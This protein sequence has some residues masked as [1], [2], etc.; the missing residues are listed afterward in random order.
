MVLGGLALGVVFVA[1]FVMRTLY[2]ARPMYLLMVILLVAGIQM[3][4]FG[5]I[6]NQ[7]GNIKKEIY[8]LQRQRKQKNNTWNQNSSDE[9]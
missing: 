7:I 1:Q 6:S 2:P 5:F 3:L 4:S 8:R 9:D